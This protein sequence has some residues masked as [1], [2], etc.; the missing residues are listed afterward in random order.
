MKK[1]LTGIILL[2]LLVL[3]LFVVAE[4]PL[5]DDVEEDECAGVS[6]WFKCLLFGDPSQRAV[7]GSAWYD[8]GLPYYDPEG[9]ALVGKGGMLESSPPTE[10]DIEEFGSDDSE[11]SNVVLEITHAVEQGD[12][13]RLWDVTP[14]KEDIDYVVVQEA[15]GRIRVEIDEQDISYENGDIIGY[16]DATGTQI[17]F[18]RDILEVE[19]WDELENVLNTH[20]MASSGDW[21]YSVKINEPGA[22][23]QEYSVGEQSQFSTDFREIRSRNV[24]TS[25]EAGTSGYY[26]YAGQTWYLGEDDS[27]YILQDDGSWILAEESGSDQIR[28][29]AGDLT[30]APEGVGV[31]PRVRPSGVPED[32]EYHSDRGI[33]VS[34]DQEA[35]WT[36]EGEQV[37]TLW[38]VG[39][40]KWVEISVRENEFNEE[41]QPRLLQEY[42]NWRDDYCNQNYGSAVYS[43][44]EALDIGG[45]QARSEWSEGEEMEMV[46]LETPLPE[47]ILGE[48]TALVEEDGEETEE[49]IVQLPSELAEEPTPTE[50]AAKTETELTDQ[51]L[52]EANLAAFEKY[53]ENSDNP[54]RVGSIEMS[55]GI[56]LEGHGEEGELTYLVSIT[57]PATPGEE[58]ETGPSETTYYYRGSE[59]GTQTTP[60]QIVIDGQTYQTDAA[61]I[62][63]AL[64]S[65]QGLTYYEFDEETGERSEEAYANRRIGEEGEDISTNYDLEQQT[66]DYANGRRRV[67]DGDV[68]D[69]EFTG[70]FE[71]VLEENEQGIYVVKH[72]RDWDDDGNAKILGSDGYAAGGTVDGIDYIQEG[73]NMVMVIGDQSSEFHDSGERT[74]AGQVIWVNDQ[75]QSPDAYAHV[76]REGASKLSD[77]Q[78][79]ANEY[80][81]NL[82]GAIG[83]SLEEFDR[84]NNLISEESLMNFDQFES[85]GTV[86]HQEGQQ[87][88]EGTN[89]G[90]FYRQGDDET[91]FYLDVDGNIIYTQGSAD[92]EP[93][94]FIGE[95]YILSEDYSDALSGASQNEE[96]RERIPQ[97][98]I[99]L[100]A[101]RAY[102]SGDFSEMSNE[103]MEIV[104]NEVFGM[105]VVDYFDSK[106]SPEEEY[107]PGTTNWDVVRKALIEDREAMEEAGEIAAVN[108]P[109]P[110]DLNAEM[111]NQQQRATSTLE[112]FQRG[113]SAVYAITSSVRAYPALSNL[114]DINWLPGADKAFAPLLGENW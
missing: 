2:L 31:P 36:N 73:D 81:N 59:V 22:N 106:F 51:Q 78:S 27:V 55:N 29:G 72:Y 79:Q 67:I 84:L 108:A 10:R 104:I 4:N 42:F 32:A 45:G 87:M 15:S 21:R 66:I 109:P 76:Q 68:D 61:D 63:A 47:G 77:E 54:I 114:L 93:Q 35:M 110:G 71:T 38:G 102:E 34:T 100:N 3:A 40:N 13:A 111:N 65:N 48:R 14:W 46:S 86:Y 16:D 94:P 7:A 24:G 83:E 112:G 26:D 60:N 95:R 99:R 92:N 69:G 52:E 43:C 74:A 8:R 33:W 37:T 53:Q 75:G 1:R 80:R 19:T 89:Y 85:S 105:S 9:E 30:I 11:E 70:D 88:I 107:A 101:L 28:E 49:E 17:A 12:H 20:G 90:V 82:G 97:E 96:Y 23:S 103:Q 98:Q 57:Q 50:P 41:D 25:S 39:Y 113:I 18:T 56:I 58:G 91:L 64:V 6:G 62:G 5:Q 44:Q